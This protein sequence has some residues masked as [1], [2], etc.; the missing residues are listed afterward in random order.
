MI[1]RRPRHSSASAQS[2]QWSSCRALIWIDVQDEKDR[3]AREIRDLQEKRRLYDQRVAHFHQQLVPGYA[4]WMEQQFGEAQ[5]RIQALQ[6]ERHLMQRRLSFAQQILHFAPELKRREI[7]QIVQ[8]ALD[9]QIEPLV[10]LHNW[11]QE[12]LALTRDP[13]ESTAQRERRQMQ[14]IRHSADLLSDLLLARFQQEFEAQGQVQISAIPDEWMQK[15]MQQFIEHFL[16][17]D[18]KPALV[19]LLYLRQESVRQQI[20]AM[21]REFLQAHFPA[22][23][24]ESGGFADA[25]YESFEE[26]L[27][28]FGGGFAGRFGRSNPPRSSPPSQESAAQLKA[29]YRR[30]ARELHPDT[31]NLPEADTALWMEVQSLYQSGNLQGLLR[32]EMNLALQNPGMQLEAFDLSN[33]RETRE[34]LK[35][36]VHERK[37]LW[38]RLSKRP[39]AKLGR[40]AHAPARLEK[41]QQK[42]QREFETQE[43]ELS[44]ELVQMRALWASLDRRRRPRSR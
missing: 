39:E 30:L 7:E 11:I 14:V 8:R 32:V 21:V 25:L 2:V 36:E 4:A 23:K 24:P 33:L 6:A 3:M 26:I 31:G 34:A 38:Q 17:E 16:Q 37:N 29:V 5:K 18:G 40:H 1:F 9:E 41:L 42:I 10:A 35:Q 20:E 12:Q 13:M 28:R 22:T 15:M 19:L 27:G 44:I 43:D